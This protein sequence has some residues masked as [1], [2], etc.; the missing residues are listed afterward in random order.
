MNALA[1]FVGA[2]KLPK[3]SRDDIEGMKLSLLPRKEFRDKLRGYPD[4]LSWAWCIDDGI[5]E[6]NDGLL[7]AGWYFRG[8]DMGSATHGEMAALSA[9]INM[10]LKDSFDG[11]WSLH[12][13]SIRRYT[14]EYPTQGA[15]PDKTTLSI[16]A[17]RRAMYQ[18]EGVHLQ[19]MYAITLAW[20]IPG[21]GGAKAEQWFYNADHELESSGTHKDRMLAKFKQAIKDFEVQMSGILQIA[22]MKS[23]ST[24]ANFRGVEQFNCEFLEYLNY[25][26]TGSYRPVAL[27]EGE[28]GLEMILGECSFEPM[29][30][31]G[32]KLGGLYGK[33]I[34]IT[35]FPSTTSPGILAALDALGFEYRWNTRYWFMD[36]HTAEAHITKHRRNWEQKITGMVDQMRSNA[37]AKVDADAVSMTGDAQ[38]ALSELKSSNVSYGTYSSTIIVLDADPVMLEDKFNQVR[39]AVAMRSFGVID[40]GLNAGEAFL[41][42]LPGNRY[43][44]VRGGLVSSLNLSDM[45]PITSVWAGFESNPNPFLGGDAPPLAHVSTTGS[46]PFRLSLHVDDVGHTLMLGPTGSG[47]TTCLNFLQAQHFRYPNARIFGFD[48]KLGSYVLGKAAGASYYH[49][50]S[51][52]E[53]LSFCPLAHI[54]GADDQAWAADWLESCLAVQD[55][56]GSVAM[57]KE[58]FRALQELQRSTSRSMTEYIHILQV[59]EL[60]EGLKFYTLGGQMG[61]L[62]D[63]EADSLG[64]S[65]WMM[66]EMESLFSKGAKYSTPVLLYLFRELERR[67]DGRLTFI[68]CDEVWRGL[69][70]PIFEEKLKELLKTLR[71]K[72]AYVCL[73]S[74][75]PGDV[76]KS[77]IRDAILASCPTKILLANPDAVGVQHDLYRDHLQLNAQEIDLIA[78]MTRKRHYYYRSPAGRRAFAL[79]L[80]PVALAF[81]GASGKEEIALADQFM[82]EHGANWPAEWLRM[83]GLPDWADYWQHAA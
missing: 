57:R 45:L 44:N 64:D 9:R 50:G 49:I 65:R 76:L 8:E 32:F 35:G 25:C 77:N 42:T 36:Q 5:V 24:G 14:K 10:I 40:E 54:D 6:T 62:L 1:K 41:G 26:A 3:I 56:K 38:A 81:A 63:D 12:V 7:L 47:K 75:E 69:D 43:A 2:F 20:E 34:S 30:G 48:Y 37:K 15:F 19:S 71:S 66:F 13:D 83:K 31:K 11:R 68:P 80:G 29:S 23:Y 55:I 46:T 51:N 70:N 74:Q 72:N 18:A 53:G 59:D 33:A 16:D 52:G 21:Q 79:G 61:R 4:L 73:A 58:L 39:N 78:T 82:K 17:E 27:G 28:C 22:R 60:R 67:L